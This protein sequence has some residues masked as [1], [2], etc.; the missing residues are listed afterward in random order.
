MVLLC[1]FFSVWC[2]SHYCTVCILCSLEEEYATKLH[3]MEQ[4]HKEELLALGMT[5]ESQAEEPQ[6][7]IVD[8]TSEDI[9]DKETKERKQSKARRKR[10]QE[11]LKQ[12]QLQEE[13]ER[14]LEGPSAR[15]EELEMIQTLL[16]PLGM[17]I[18]PVTSDGHCLYRAVAEQV[19]NKN[20]LD[21]RELCILYARSFFLTSIQ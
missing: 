5:D 14:D 15:K 19:G 21:L 2:F 1:A 11:R 4:R 10:E 12:K 18:Y 8:K 13:Q 6:A 9:M 7:S 16:T 20:Y 17:A 3:E